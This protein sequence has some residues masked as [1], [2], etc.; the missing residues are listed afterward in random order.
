MCHAMP[1]AQR[2]KIFEMGIAH[3]CHALSEQERDTCHGRDT[4]VCCLV[5]EWEGHISWKRL[6]LLVMKETDHRMYI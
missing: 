1:M 2:L 3:M 4:E 6:A 5:R